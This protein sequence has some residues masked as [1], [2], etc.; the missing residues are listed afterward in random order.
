VLNF[1]SKRA[2]IKMAGQI[3]AAY[4]RAFVNN[5]EYYPLT[6]REIKQVVDNIMV[7]AVPELIKLISYNDQI[8]GFLLGFPDISAAMQRHGGHITPWAIADFM[9]ELKRTNFISFNGVGVL[10]EYQGRGGNTLM[11]DEMANLMLHSR[12]V[13]S[14]LTHMAETATQVRKDIITAGSKPWKNHRIFAKSV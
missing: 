9:I 3:G 11:Y 8:V 5:W 10:P 13:E 6:E 7:V 2:L 1:T 14:E 12:Y 4:N